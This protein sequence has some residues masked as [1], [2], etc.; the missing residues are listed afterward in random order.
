MIRDEEAKQS[1]FNTRRDRILSVAQQAVACFGYSK[2]T[3]THIAEQIGISKS[4]IYKF[5]DSKKDI[6]NALSS[7]I[8]HSIEENAAET[9]CKDGSARV[10]LHTFIVMTCLATSRSTVND[11]HVYDLIS[12][13]FWEN[14]A[15]TTDHESRL[16]SLAAA[17]LHDGKVAGEFDCDLQVDNVA[18]AIGLVLRTFRPP[19]LPRA[20]LDHPDREAQL[21][22]D[23]ILRSVSRSSACVGDR[24][25]ALLEAPTSAYQ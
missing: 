25:V 1:A 4:Y 19:A 16:R 17:I 10:R 5:F 22:A 13:S 7:R 12:M 15:A 18:L 11:R 3:V 24:A 23:L 2:L 6:G 21:V 14:W 20:G 8:F 9:T